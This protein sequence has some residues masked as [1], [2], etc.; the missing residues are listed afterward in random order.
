MW[1][2]QRKENQGKVKVVAELIS[3]PVSDGFIKTPLFKP[4]RAAYSGCIHHSRS[5]GKYQRGDLLH[6]GRGWFKLPNSVNPGDII[7]FQSVLGRLTGDAVLSVEK[8]GNG[9]IAGKLYASVE[10]AKKAGSKKPAK[11]APASKKAAKGK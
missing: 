9:E 3:L 6:N 5:D 1:L 7:E 2:T 10:S 11:K 8:Y 4:G